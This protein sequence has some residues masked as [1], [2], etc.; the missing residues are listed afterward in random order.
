M[1]EG[2][3]L[4][5]LTRQCA[6]YM[7]VSNAVAAGF[8]PDCWSRLYAKLSPP[9]GVMDGVIFLH[10][11]V[12]PAGGRRL[13]VVELRNGP[14]LGAVA[15]S[16]VFALG[17]LLDKPKELASYDGGHVFDPRARVYAG[18]PDPNDASHFT[19]EVRTDGA[20]EGYDG[21]LTDDDQILIERRN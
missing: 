20:T 13:V 17:G 4:S 6:T 2:I 1:L 9:G 14:S 7:P 12:S 3:D 11:R 21:W 8:V 10:E 5:L 19:F 16:R 15:Y 18:V